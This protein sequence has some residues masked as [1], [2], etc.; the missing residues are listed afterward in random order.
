MRT[1]FRGLGDDTPCKPTNVKAGLDIATGKL[2]LSWDAVTKGINNGYVGDVTYDVVRYPDNKT[3]ASATTNTSLTDQL[4]GG[5]LTGY[6]YTVTARSGQSKSEPAQSNSVSYGDMLEP[7]YQQGF[8]NEASLNVFTIIDA[9][10]DG[11][12][13]KFCKNDGTGQSS[14]QIEYGDNVTD[15]DDW[16]IMPPLKLKK[17]QVYN[18]SFRVASVGESY[19]EELEVM[20][21]SE[22]TAEAMTHTLMAKTKI[23]NREYETLK[24]ELT[25]DKDGAVYIG[26]H[27]ISSADYYYALVLDDIS[28]KGN[29]QKAPDA[30][31]NLRVVPAEDGSAKATFYF[32]APTKA[33]DGTKLTSD[34]DVYVMR[35]GEEIQQMAA[36]KP[37][38][39][40]YYIDNSAQNGVNNY[41]VIASNEEG[42][43]RES[44]KVSAYVG[45]DTP[46]SP[47]GIKA[48]T[49]DTDITLTWDPVTKGTNGGYIDPND[50]VYNVY[51]IIETGTG[52]SLPLVD[53]VSATTITIPYDTN[54]GEQEMINYALSAENSVDEGPRVMSPGIIVGTPYTL[55]FEEH[56]KGGRL[57][58]AMWWTDQTGE[59]GFDLMQ[60]MSSEG[61]GGCTGYIA[62]QDSAERSRESDARILLYVNGSKGADQHRALR[63]DSRQ[64]RRALQDIQVRR[65]R[66]VCMDNDVR[67]AR[68]ESCKSE[69][70]HA[71][72]HRSD[73]CRHSTIYR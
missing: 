33:I 59:V 57:D 27:C 61:D 42:K 58:N 56:F 5:N 67:T 37:G 15:H 8:D 53:Q 73:T 23:S 71:D 47:T 50:V 72:V 9:N 66:I 16:L 62:G 12:T 34:L 52:V 49:T 46:A 41:S 64:G 35:D 60:G 14:A 24:A 11:A 1:I 65:R 17:G 29:S 21:G 25:P 36:I 30:A 20:Y 31:T 43:G 7:P 39:D 18:V 51:E 13:W 68:Q 54:D 2:S 32:T 40:Y 4:P 10:N 70:C 48:M 3:L 44:Q 6:Y 69:V 55:P 22:P 45:K 63:K 38:N 28:V 26:F 19:P